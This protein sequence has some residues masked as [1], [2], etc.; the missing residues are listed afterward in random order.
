MPNCDDSSHLPV[1]VP[2]LLWNAKEQFNI[3]PTNKSDLHPT[4]ALTKMK[5]LMESLCVIP[6]IKNRPDPLLQEAH[7]NSTWLFKI[8]L[9]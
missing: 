1:N 5:E 6:G 4:Y 8:Y 3:K 2:R 7:K 9:R